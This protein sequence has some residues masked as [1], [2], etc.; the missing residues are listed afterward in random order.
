MT[1]T[2]QTRALCDTCETE[3]P[4][5]RYNRAGANP[6]TCFRCRSKGISLAL[7]G[8]KEY[9]NADTEKRRAE[10]AIAEG[11]A[12]G[13]DPVPVRTAA[14]SVSAT[15]LK[16]LPGIS[17]ANGA[18]GGKPAPSLVKAPAAKVKVGS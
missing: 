5:D 1:L 17:K 15:A 7:Q 6:Q 18:F 12:A 16:A 3:W 13:F 8:G 2:Q 4:E 9:W 10:R 11:K 14:T